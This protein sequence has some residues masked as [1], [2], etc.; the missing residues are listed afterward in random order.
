MIRKIAT[1]ETE[2][3]A[4]VVTFR[5]K[6]SNKTEQ[7][8]QEHRLQLPDRLEFAAELPVDS[9]PG[10]RGRFRRGQVVPLGLLRPLGET[11]PSSGLDLSEQNGCLWL[12]TRLH[13]LT[14]TSPQQPPAVRSQAE[15]E[16]AVALRHETL[17]LRLVIQKAIMA[18]VGGKRSLECRA[19]S[20]CRAWVL[21]A[22]S[23]L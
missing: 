14:R 10:K 16:R 5:G 9:G 7:S 2:H 3:P 18:M 22:P 23:W 1:L 15:P 13:P 12:R 17:L 11:L 8:I 6:R 19:L 4:E 20:C 21:F